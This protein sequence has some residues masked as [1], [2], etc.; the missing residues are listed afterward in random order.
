MRLG[1]LIFDVDGTLADTEEAHRLAFNAA[2]AAQGLQWVWGRRLYRESLKVTGGRERIAHFIGTMKIA[3]RKKQMLLSR[4][5][6]IHVEK[7]RFYADLVA[8]GRVQL[9]PGVSALFEEA[10][11]ADLKLALA[12]TTSRANVDALVC[13]ALGG[14]ALKWFSVIATGE[15]G[16]PKKPAPDIYHHVLK[17]LDLSAQDAI[18]F[19]D[20]LNGVEAAR[21]ARIFTVATPTVWT[22]HEDLSG[23][24]LIL[25]SLDKCGGLHALAKAHAQPK[26]A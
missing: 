25:T 12:T 8:Q 3:G 17:E 22:K 1:S 16:V 9:R 23:A 5:E 4:V 18:A 11:R 24:N 21:A 20:S 14:Q 26:H 7:T 6:A 15:T 2:F 19:E 10:R 13:R